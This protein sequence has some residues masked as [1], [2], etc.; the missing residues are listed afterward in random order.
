MMDAGLEQ[1][2]IAVVDCRYTEFG[3]ACWAQ[4]IRPGAEAANPFQ[5]AGTFVKEG[6][7]LMNSLDENHHPHAGSVYSVLVS[8]TP[9]RHWPMQCWS[10]GHDAVG[11]GML[12]A[13]PM[14]DILS[15]QLIGSAH[16]VAEMANRALDQLAATDSMDDDDGDD[17][18]DDDDPDPNPDAGDD[19]DGGDNDDQTVAATS[20]A[21]AADQDPASDTD[22]SV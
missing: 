22:A 14:G 17:A 10:A 1:F 5:P 8:T 4:I 16:L 20:I 6:V 3:A 12:G 21:S 19:D 13:P 9:G 7:F 2:I 11:L 15:F 18:A